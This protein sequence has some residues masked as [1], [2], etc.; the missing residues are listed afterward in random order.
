LP[1][2]ALRNCR[3]TAYLSRNWDE[4]RPFQNGPEVANLGDFQ[5]N[6]LPLG[7][8]DTPCRES[9]DKAP[10]RD[11][12]PD[13]LRWS[14][15][16][17]CPVAFMSNHPIGS[18][19]QLRQRVDAIDDQLVALLNARANIAIEIAAAKRLRGLPPHS[20]ER[21]SE[22]VDRAQARNPGP[23]SNASLA[24]VFE[25]VFSATAELLDPPQRPG[26]S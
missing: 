14:T 26:T 24:A 11:R 15:G 25:A 5:G 16:K 7:F 6:P 9:R 12:R 18:V 20:P 3:S 21:E 2:D 1:T 8:V 23:I 13:G 19:E 10:A 22:V 17:N 4:S